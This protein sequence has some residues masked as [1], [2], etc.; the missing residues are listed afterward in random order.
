MTKRVVLHRIALLA[1]TA[2]PC[3]KGIQASK[4]CSMQACAGGDDEPWWLNNS[5]NKAEQAACKHLCHRSFQ[6]VL[7]HANACK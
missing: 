7:G 2:R 5:V 1:A 6:R 3:A 4:I